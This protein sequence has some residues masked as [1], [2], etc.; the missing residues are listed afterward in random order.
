MAEIDL[1]VTKLGKATIPSPLNDVNYEEENSTVVYEKD[2]RKIVEEY[3]RDGKLLAFEKAGPQRMV[4]HDSAWSKAAILTAGGICPGLNDVIKGLTRTLMVRYQVPIV[5]G[6]KYGYQGLVPAFGH[7]PLLLT[8]DMVDDIHE[9]GGTI[10]GS[11]R[12]RQDEKIMVDTL[13]RMN[14]N[15]LFCVGGDGTLRCAHD[16]VKEIARRRLN[17]SVIGIPKTIDNDISFIDKTFGFET[18]VYA[19]NSVIM[20]AHN[21]AKGAP[22]GIGLIHVMGRDSGFIAAY[23]TLANTHINYCLVPEVEFQLY[24]GPLALLPSLGRRLKERKH[25]VIIVAEGAGQYLFKNQD[26]GRDKSGNKLHNNIGLFLKDEINQWATDNKFDVNVKYFDPSYMIRSLPANGT[27]AVFCQLLAQCAVHAAMHG[28]TDMVVGHW[29]ESFTHVPIAMA[30][31]QRKKIDPKSQ[32]W[33]SVKSVTWS[34]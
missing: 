22:N 15:M 10:L 34:H 26:G 30:T 33:L 31:S 3:R 5:Y 14:I 24:D 1:S 17:I 19:T 11:S 21:E 28:C 12:G 16:I 4:Y 9:S 6:I 13:E 32:I 7:E 25:A 20:A 2:A 23:A 8:P 29:N 27:D 18:A